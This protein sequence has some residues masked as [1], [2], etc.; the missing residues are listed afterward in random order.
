MKKVHKTVQK[1]KTKKC[2]CTFVQEKCKKRSR[3]SGRLNTKRGM[4]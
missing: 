3:K 2:K 4:E 1:C